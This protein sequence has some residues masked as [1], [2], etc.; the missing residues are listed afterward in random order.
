MRV[1]TD[2][3]FDFCSTCQR[4]DFNVGVTDMYADG[5]VY[6]REVRIYCLYSYI[7]AGVADE[8]ARKFLNGEQNIDENAH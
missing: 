6:D 2:L 8:L 3:P 7:C 4:H 1:T 5:R